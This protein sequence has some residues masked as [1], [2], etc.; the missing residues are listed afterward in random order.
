MVAFEQARRVSSTPHVVALGQ[1]GG[2]VQGDTK[3]GQEVF[4]VYA[5]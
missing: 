5:N 4:F 1:F 2:K 3:D